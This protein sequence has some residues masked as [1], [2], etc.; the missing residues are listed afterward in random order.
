MSKREE[1]FSLHWGLLSIFGGDQGENTL[2]T[3]GAYTDQAPY[4]SLGE[5][6]FV[7]PPLPIWGVSW[8]AKFAGQTIPS[9]RALSAIIAA[10]GL[11]G[12]YFL[13]NTFLSKELSILAPGFL[14]GSLIWNGYARQSTQDIWGI[15]FFLLSSAFIFSFYKKENS[16]FSFRKIIG[17]PLLIALCTVL[18]GLS[19]FIGFALF[20]ILSLLFIIIHPVKPLFTILSL[21]GIV[22][23]TCLSMIWYVKMDLPFWSQISAAVFGFTF[24]FSFSALESILTDF[25]LFPAAIAGLIVLPFSHMLLKST[26]TLYFIPKR[27]WFLITWFIVTF[28][29]TSQFSIFILPI[30]I[31]LA[32]TCIEI[33]PKLAMNKGFI[34]MIASSMSVFALFGIIPRIPHAFI[35][36]IQ[37]QIYSIPGIICIPICII[38]FLGFILSDKIIKEINARMLISIVIVLL[39]AGIMKV[40]FSNILGIAPPQSSPA[41]FSKL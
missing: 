34:W 21:F 35:N 11:L 39:I 8:W 6:T 40:A 19:S 20:L 5:S 33:L 9:T 24:S 12:F 28:L 26:A 18:L 27:S 32:L 16:F 4:L 36:L 14:A 25:S 3:W 41:V 2:N 23:G 10:F 38:P 22:I 30:Y 37:H 15:T 1:S 7:E 13:S 17:Y 31:L 29:L